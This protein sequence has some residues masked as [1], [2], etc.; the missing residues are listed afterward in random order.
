MTSHLGGREGSY[1]ND[2]FS[3]RVLTECFP[4]DYAAAQPLIIKAIVWQWEEEQWKLRE[5]V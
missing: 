4:K 3:L 2:T 5:L 1:H